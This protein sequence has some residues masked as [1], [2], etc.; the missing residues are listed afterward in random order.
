MY[1]RQKSGQRVQNSQ[2]KDQVTSHL[3]WESINS[4]LR[5]TVGIHLYTRVD[6]HSRSK[7]RIG[8]IF[9]PLWGFSMKIAF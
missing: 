4:V 5:A 6:S 3:L 8:L 9:D 7:D 1:P 2:N